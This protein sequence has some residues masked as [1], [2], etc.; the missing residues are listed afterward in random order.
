ML[1]YS[2][3]NLVMFSQ[4]RKKFVEKGIDFYKFLLYNKNKKL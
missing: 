3:H 2:T 4:I 1:S